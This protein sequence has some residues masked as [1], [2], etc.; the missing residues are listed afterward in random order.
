VEFILNKNTDSTWNLTPT[1]GAFSGLVIAK[2]EG[3]NLYGARFY[4]GN[5]IGALRSVW[6]LTVFEED[7]YTDIT[8]LRALCLGKPFDSDFEQ[9]ASMDSD[10]VRDSFTL[11]LL[12]GAKRVM[13]LGQSIYMKGSY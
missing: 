4:N 10:G 11:R 6:G 2:V 7:V 5:M 12:K 8:T 13:L 9:A 1:E 3:V